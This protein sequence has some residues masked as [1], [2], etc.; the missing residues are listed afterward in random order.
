MGQFNSNP[1]GSTTF[2][3]DSSGSVTPFPGGSEN[4]VFAAP[5]GEVA[6]TYGSLRFRLT[7]MLPGIDPDLID[8]WISDRYTAI[9]DRLPWQRL[10]KS[11]AFETIAP[12]SAGLIS[13]SAGSA[14]VGLAGGAWTVAMTGLSIRIDNRDEYYEF[15]PTSP[16][17]GTLDRPFEGSTAGAL[18][19]CIFA[20]VY[21]LPP[22]CRELRA[23]RL[24]DWPRALA[25]RTKQEVNAHAASRS[26]QG[27]PVEYAPY[28]DDTSAPPR[29]QIEVYPAPDAVRTLVVDYIAEVASPSGTSTALLPWVRPAAL[30]EGVRASGLDHLKDYSG[31]D[32]AEARF[33]ALLEQMVTIDSRNRPPRQMRMAPRFTR[34]RL[35]RSL[36]SYPTNSGRL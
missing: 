24:M 4:R 19:Y 17:A 21:Q 33:Q 12:Y 36:N 14:N 26:T 20:T 35:Q 22:D 31:S 28:M 5:A 25:R 8:G 15:T 1:F 32:R 13:A 23:I 10:E 34:H 11:F 18:A 16:T 29:L 27:P 3:G 6:T 9:L 2:N 30:I 7:K